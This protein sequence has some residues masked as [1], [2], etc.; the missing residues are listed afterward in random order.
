MPPEKTV[1]INLKNDTVDDAHMIFRGL[2]CVGYLK[3]ALV[4][5]QG[6]EIF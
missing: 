3:T 1:K 2:S 6:A 5:N 4:I